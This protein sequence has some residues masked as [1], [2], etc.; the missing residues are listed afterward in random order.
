MAKETIEFMSIPAFG[1][2]VLGIGEG[3]A[4]AAAE[5]GDIVTVRIGKLRRVPVK[6]A[7]E[8]LRAA[9]NNKKES[10]S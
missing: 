2:E 8:Q 10:E 4:R 7:M 3:A 9:A 5:R 6:L 1:R